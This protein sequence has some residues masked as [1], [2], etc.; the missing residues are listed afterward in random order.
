MT[1]PTFA[2][3]DLFWE[4]GD[5]G[6]AWLVCDSPDRDAFATVSRNQAL[7]ADDKFHWTV[8]GRDSRG[9][10]TAISRGVAESMPKAKSCVDDFLLKMNFEQKSQFWA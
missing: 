5:G 4:G 3:Q 6:F 1:E 7:Y 2:M 8:H 9:V 10:A